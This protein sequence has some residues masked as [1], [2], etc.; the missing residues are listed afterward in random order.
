MDIG[1]TPK[2]CQFL[3]RYRT[4]C[5]KEKG[6]TRNGIWTCQFLIRYRTR[7]WGAYYRLIKK[8]GEYAKCQF[9]IRY[10][11]SKDYYNLY[12]HIVECQFLIRYRTRWM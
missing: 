5:K 1:L 11:T 7:Y 8:I 6:G 2:V 3:I 9:L 12:S 10:R 4:S